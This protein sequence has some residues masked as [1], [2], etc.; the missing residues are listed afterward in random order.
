MTKVTGRLALLAAAGIAGCGGSGGGGGG[1]VCPTGSGSGTLALHITGTPS[2]NGI[3]SVSGGTPVTTADA[4]TSLPA[5]AAGVVAYLYAE[6]GGMV[7]TAYQPTVDNP[8]PCVLAGQVTT[9][10]V[11]YALIPTS[12]LLWAG[13]ENTPSTA[14]LLGYDPASIAASGTAVAAVAADTAGS[15]GFTFDKYGNIWVTGA[16]AGDPPVARYPASDFLT[17]G[18][19]TPDLV[20]TSSTLT[21]A[22]PGPAA[23][24]FDGDGGLWVSVTGSNKV[25]K[26]SASQ[27][28]AGAT[29]ITAPPAVEEAG[30]NG[31]Q[32]IAFDL[33]GNLWIADSGNDAVVR[34]DAAHLTSSG[35][36]ADLT[37][38]AL[39]PGPV[40]ST[41]GSPLGL[42]FDVGGNLW[43]NYYGTMARLDAGDLA[44]TGTVTVTPAIQIVVDVLSLPT[45]IAF[46][47]LGGLWFAYASGYFARLSSAQLQV[48]GTQ[49]PA[50]IVDGTDLGDAGWF[51]I[52][53]AP[54]LT[55]LAHAF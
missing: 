5:G 53:P 25:V 1:G 30:T 13:A 35:T 46:D 6:P 8:N 22:V 31:P 47:E 10:N 16:A 23:L 20:I 51:A 7:R 32:G 43:V 3:V 24:A 11:A 17:D 19:K 40:I 18:S 52:Y 38:T 44:G 50:T 21:A 4:Q 12:G 42:A 15:G 37:I 9:V 33:D 14:T 49:T 39:T 45:G 28:D 27:L 54:A 29:T 41:L 2:G 48:S 36:G 55:P 34:I 26:F